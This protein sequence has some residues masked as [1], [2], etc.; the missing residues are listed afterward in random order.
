MIAR[1]ILFFSHVLFYLFLTEKGVITQI[2]CKGTHKRR[3]NKI[4]LHLFAFIQL[5]IKGREIRCMRNLLLPLTE[6]VAKSNRNLRSA[7]LNVRS[8]T[9][10][11][12]S[13]TLNVRSTTLNGD[14][15]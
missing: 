14:L 12:C 11:V 1:L 6:I 8:A 4:K 2:V 15:Y 13:A 7:S 9:L 5:I 3:D 10:N